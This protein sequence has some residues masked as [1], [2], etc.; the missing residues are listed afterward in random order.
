MGAGKSAS[1][2]EGI[3]R[4]LASL[5]NSRRLMLLISLPADGSEVSLSS[6]GEDL[7]MP[8]ST[9]SGFVSDLYEIGLIRIRV[10]GR[11]RYV[12]LAQPDVLRIIDAFGD[13]GWITS[14]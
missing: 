2:V 10:E 1:E 5:G 3:S 14:N 7:Q 13:V 8:Q 6:L 12:R 11:W 4:V 9:I